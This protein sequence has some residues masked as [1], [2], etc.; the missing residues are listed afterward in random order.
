M[1]T[2]EFVGKIP[3]A[4]P[5]VDVYDVQLNERILIEASELEGDHTQGEVGE[6]DGD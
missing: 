2:K 4:M 1:K 6:A 5:T 3:Y